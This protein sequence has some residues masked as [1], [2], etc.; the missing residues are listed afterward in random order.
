V[1]ASRRQRWVLATGNPGKVAEFRALLAD[2]PIEL[3]TLA[4]L[5]AAQADETGA[6]FVENALLKARAAA[7]ATGLP[8]IADDSG[9]VVPALGGSPGVRSAR[10][11]GSAATD[12][13]NTARLLERMAVLDGQDRAARFVCVIVALHSVADPAPVIAEGCWSGSIARAPRGRHGFGYDPV[14]IDATSTLTAAEL[15][16]AEKNARS[17]RGIAAAA[18]ADRL[19]RCAGPP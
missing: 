17:H 13:E 9:L 8:A 14:F 11:A 3:V 4:E 18:L 2:L 16:P 6:T 1:S 5:T 10:F 19:R 15:Q 7:S 12:D